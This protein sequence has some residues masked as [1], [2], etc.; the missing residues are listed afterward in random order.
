MPFEGVCAGGTQDQREGVG[1]GC[2]PSGERTSNMG[3]V[4]RKQE[5]GDGG[6]DK[7]P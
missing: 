3:L 4:L 2:Q 6:L 1:G 7:W 5:R